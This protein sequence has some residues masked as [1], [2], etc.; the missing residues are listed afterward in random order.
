MDSKNNKSYQ[1]GGNLTHSKVD[2]TKTSDIVRESITI[3]EQLA[4]LAECFRPYKPEVK[5]FRID[6]LDRSSEIKYYLEIPAG[7]RRAIHR[8]RLEVPAQIGFKIDELLDLDTGNIVSQFKYDATE[9]KWIFDLNTFPNSERYILT[10]KGRIPIE[11][12][13]RIAD[14]KAAANPSRTNGIDKYWLHAALKDVSILKRWWDELDVERVNADVRVGIQ[15]YF[16]SSIP[17]QV[18]ERLEVERELLDA[19]AQGDRGMQR[20][21]ETKYRSLQRIVKISSTELYELISKLVSGEFFIN[22][23]RVD[24]PFV[25]GTIEPIR[26]LT[27]IIPEQIKISVQTDL[28]FYR[29]AVR[30]NLSFE[31]AKYIEDISDAIEE[32]TSSKK[33]RKI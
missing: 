19:V 23:L 4:K 10:L 28:N 3:T 8:N 17:S 6:Y 13:N 12:L 25:F 18:R 14:I 32:A 9:N 5:K 16:T 2:P 27:A 7:I 29:P 21:L 33:R 15:R 1:G 30:G 24:D 31:R 11:L 20:R 22:Y 26:E